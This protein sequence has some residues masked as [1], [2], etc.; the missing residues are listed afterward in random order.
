MS[1][2]AWISSSNCSACCRTVPSVVAMI[3]GQVA[4]GAFELQV[5]VADDHVERRAQL[6]RHRRHELFLELVG[7]LQIGDQVGVVERRRRHARAMPARMRASRAVEGALAVGARGE[8]QAAQ[9]IAAL[10]PHAEQAAGAAS[11]AAGRAASARA[12]CRRRAARPRR[13]T[14]G[15]ASAAS[16]A[17]PRPGAARCP[18]ARAGRGSRRRGRSR[19]LRPTAAARC[20]PR[21]PACPMPRAIWSAMALGSSAA[22][23]PVATSSTARR[24][25]A[26]LP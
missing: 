11:A 9:L 18:A 15:R 24:H 13:P 3:L 7:R 8:Q 16:R 22:V 21:A 20:R 26:S 4:E 19:S 14:A 1:S 10:Q 6:V 25:L 23:M 5:G 17:A 12:R 2:V